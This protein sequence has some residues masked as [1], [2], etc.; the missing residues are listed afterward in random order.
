MGITPQNI[1]PLDGGQGLRRRKEL[2]QR[3][4]AGRGSWRTMRKQVVSSHCLDLAH[5][6]LMK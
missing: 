3:R 5:F 2:R 1:A 4:E 6:T